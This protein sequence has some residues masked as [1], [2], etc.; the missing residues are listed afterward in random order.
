MK[1]ISR[2]ILLS[3]SCLI[4]YGADNVCASVNVYSGIPKS[5]THTHYITHLTEPHLSHPRGGTSEASISLCSKRY[6][7]SFEGLIPPRELLP[8]GENNKLNVFKTASVCFITDTGE[9]SGDK[10]GNSENVSGGNG[11]PGGGWKP[12]EPAL[13]NDESCQA[14][15]YTK[16]PCPEGKEPIRYCPY[17]SS[18]HAACVCPPEYS[19]TCTSPNRGV[20]ES[21]DGKY[22]EC[23]NTCPGYDYISVPAGFEVLGECD[24]CDGKKYKVK[25]P[26]SYISN[27]VC[28]ANGG[29]GVCTDDSGTYYK[30]CSCPLNYE[31]NAAQRKCVCSASF[32]YTCT[33]ANMFGGGESCDGKYRECSCANG[34]MWNDG[35][36]NLCQKLQLPDGYVYDSSECPYGVSRTLSGTAADCYRSHYQCAKCNFSNCRVGQFLEGNTCV[37]TP[38]SSWYSNLQLIIGITPIEVAAC[39]YEFH[40]LK[41][42]KTKEDCYKEPNDIKTIEFIAQNK[43]II[44]ASL[45]KIPFTLPITGFYPVDVCYVDGKYRD[46]CYNGAT[47]M[48]GRQYSYGKFDM[49]SSSLIKDHATCSVMGN[50]CDSCL[51]FASSRDECVEEC[52]IKAHYVTTNKVV[53]KGETCH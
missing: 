38:K 25:C 28:G 15:G 23:C 12:G 5:G 44:S 41:E 1:N 3:T 10:F 42:I 8:Q 53:C 46:P 18:Y 36:C 30:E 34:Y 51:A 17:D 27:T 29:K 32:K 39:K 2:V 48:I 47:D 20:G 7:L 6:N 24:S 21:C 50:A 37:D 19:Q 16:E 43:S 35:I 26:S 33:G 31:W 40:V 13:D 14:L 45:S 22:T 11:N 4:W 49:G 9:C 52:S